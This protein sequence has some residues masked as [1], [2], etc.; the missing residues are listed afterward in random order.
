MA[1]RRQ[2]LDDLIDLFTPEIRDVFLAAMQDVVDNAII[3]DMID[4]IEQGDVIAAFQALGFTQAAMLPIIKIVENAFE[5]GGVLTGDKFPKFLRTPSG[6]AIF[7][8]DVRNSRAE[9][10]LRDH[11]SQLV[12]QLTDE[13]RDNVRSVIERGM[14]AG[15]NPRSTALDIV[16]RIDP[17]TRNRVGGVVGL[18]RNQELWVANTRRDLNDL[19]RIVSDE[20][21]SIPISEFRKKI[22]NHPYFARE[23]RRKG[24]DASIIRELTSGKQI[25][26]DTIDKLVTA[27]KSNALRYRGEVIARTEAMQALNRSE[28]EA[29]LQAVDMGALRSND[30][31]R[32]WDSAGDNRVRWSHKEMDGQAVGVN[33]PFVSPSG[34]R[35]MYP[36]DTSLGA[37]GSEVIQ[38]RCRVR[39]EVDFLAAWTDE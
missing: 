21:G 27:Y 33:E 18:T 24:S 17:V 16:G 29:T 32:V 2:T 26:A 8:F 6:R 25:N 22:E 7:R 30:V 35:L 34:A 5:R 31:K 15:N 3:G 14:I 37:G 28:Y 13:A 19:N 20:F 11:S 39:M 1:N 10:W 12:T 38:C 4:A 9:A 23:L 36:G